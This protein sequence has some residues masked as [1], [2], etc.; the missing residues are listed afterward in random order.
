MVATQGAGEQPAML[1]WPDA[2]ILS[3]PSQNFTAHLHKDAC[4]QALLLP[5]PSRSSCTSGFQRRRSSYW[6]Q[7]AFASLQDVEILQQSI[8]DGQQLKFCFGKPPNLT[9]WLGSWILLRQKL[10]CANTYG[11][12]G[13]R[14]SNF[15]S[16][17]TTTKLQ[18]LCDCLLSHRCCRHRWNLWQSCSK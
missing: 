2:L 6:F 3:N 4:F 1:H 15:P 10:F 12:L 13:R 16:V 7:L 17:F 18:T 14:S 9:G 5:A 8:N 11:K